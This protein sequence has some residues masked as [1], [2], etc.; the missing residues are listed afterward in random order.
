MEDE[1]AKQ[2]ATIGEDCVIAPDPLRVKVNEDFQFA[3]EDDERHVVTLAG[4]KV[5]EDLPPGESSRFVSIT[6]PG[7][8]TYEVSACP[9]GGTVAVE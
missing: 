8:F 2:V 3:N 6:A 4:G 7:N 5:V 9:R 1:T